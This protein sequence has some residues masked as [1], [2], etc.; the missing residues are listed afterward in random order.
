MLAL[1]PI[2][3]IADSRY[4]V[5]ALLTVGRP[6]TDAQASVVSTLS[7]TRDSHSQHRWR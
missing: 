7:E 6:G 4:P 3:V 2:Q 1:G 5:S